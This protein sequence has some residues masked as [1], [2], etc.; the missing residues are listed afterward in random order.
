MEM[1]VLRKL[2]RVTISKNLLSTEESTAVL[3]K[4]PLLSWTLS[5]NP[6]QGNFIDIT[7]LDANYKPNFEFIP[8]GTMIRLLIKAWNIVFNAINNPKNPKKFENLIKVEPIKRKKKKERIGSDSNSVDMQARREKEMIKEMEQEEFLRLNSKKKLK[9]CINDTMNWQNDLDNYVYTNIHKR[10]KKL[11]THKQHVMKSAPKVLLAEDTNKDVFAIKK[12]I[13]TKERDEYLEFLTLYRTVNVDITKDIIVTIPPEHILETLDLGYEFQEGIEIF[14]RIIHEVNSLGERRRDDEQKEF[15]RK[16]NPSNI[17]STNNSPVTR[18]VTAENIEEEKKDEPKKEETK[19]RF[20]FG[21]LL[22]I[23]KKKEEVVV[24]PKS[25]TDKYLPDGSLNKGAMLKWNEF[26]RIYHG[27]YFG[28]RDEILYEQAFEAYLGL[29]TSLIKR[30]DKFTLA[31][32]EIEIRGKIQTSF[33]NVAHRVNGDMEDFCIEVFQNLK[34]QAAAK[35]KMLDAKE[36]KRNQQAT[37]ALMGN[38]VEKDE[39]EGENIDGVDNDQSPEENLPIDAEEEYEEEYEEENIQIDE[40]KQISTENATNYVKY[41]L[42]HRQNLLIWATKVLDSCVE[43]LRLRGW[44]PNVF[45]FKDT[46]PG[47]VNNTSVDPG[48]QK[49]RTSAMRLGVLRGRSYQLLDNFVQ[50]REEYRQCIKLMKRLS[51]R[52]IIIELIK[53]NLALGDLLA[54]KGLIVSLVEKEMK[55]AKDKFPKMPEIYWYDKELA[56]MILYADV[57]TDH[58]VMNGFRDNDQIIT[59]SVEDNGLLIR[60]PIGSAEVLHGKILFEDNIVRSNEIEEINR[61]NIIDK[62]LMDSRNILLTK[63]SNTKKSF[64]KQIDAASRQIDTPIDNPIQDNN[65]KVPPR[66]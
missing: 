50:A 2:T 4:L 24:K 58:L 26:P 51:T 62:D 13:Y 46:I 5:W 53:V 39:E 37:F 66:K 1:S 61:K 52:P 22:S 18:P 63:L 21:S 59:Y 27:P 38:E 43:L 36:A 60:P 57:Y 49:L 45:A 19:S 16:L 7:A 8:P 15:E 47:K 64:L 25:N 23:G 14:T 17:E 10:A 3:H 6:L 40:K 31:I 34:N 42:H 35:Q 33:L 41:L 20:G 32:R 54:G 48:S 11:F 56:L 65:K 44:E 28:P 12:G 30:A 9:K 55:G 29:G